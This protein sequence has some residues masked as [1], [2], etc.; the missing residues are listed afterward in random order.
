MKSIVFVLVTVCAAGSAAGQVQAPESVAVAPIEARTVAAG[1]MFIGSVV[2]S[3]HSIVS[4]AVDGRV[5]T[6]DVEEGDA[7]QMLEGGDSSREMGQQIAQLLTKTISIEIEAARADADLK[8]Y[9]LAELEAG[10]RPEEIEQ[11]RANFERTKALKEYALSRFNRTKA[12]YDQGRTTS[13]EDLEESLSA[14]LA[15]DQNVLA[16]QA[17]YEL[18][19]K[20]PRLERIAQARAEAAAAEAR[21][22]LLEDRLKKYTIRAPFEGFVIAKKTEVGAWLTQGDPVAEVIQLDP[23]DIHVAVP[24]AYITNVHVGSTVRIRLDASPT[25]ILLGKVWR[26]VPQADVLSRTF[27]V[28]VRLPNPRVDGA[29]LLKA[30]M[31]S[32]VFLATG[33]EQPVLM[34]P[35]DAL[36]LQSDSTSVVVVDD[37]SS[38]GPPQARIVPVELGTA[39]DAMI[40]V[41]DRTGYLR[42]DQ[43]VVVRG[44]ERLRPGQPLN[45]VPLTR[46]GVAPPKG[47]TR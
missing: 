25:T 3:R 28:I 42:A 43:F 41:T 47:Q 45:V 39:N 22:E 11:A 16:A 35:K 9:A 33:R 17:A 37:E 40:Q 34:V 27:P 20:G 14:S 8:R 7:V 1:Q 32:H 19:V 5:V 26:I 4:S 2:A 12:L 6:M 21:V 18:A 29:H 31:L 38:D 23:I 10:S 46:A 13:L 44:N 30:G 15:A 24:E 36:V